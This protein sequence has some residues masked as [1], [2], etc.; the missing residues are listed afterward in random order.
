MQ[1]T[2]EYS[3]QVKRAA[4]TAT[5]VLDADDNANLQ[6]VIRQ[7]AELR[8]KDVAS[9]LFPDGAE[10]HPSILIFVN[11]EQVRWKENPQLSDGQTVA[12][13][14]PVSGG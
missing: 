3:A 10:L 8:G 13:V 2:I 9:I 1:I 4:G 7:A 6:A 5:E 11:D 14:S 12:L